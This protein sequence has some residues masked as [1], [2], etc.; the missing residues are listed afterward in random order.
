MVKY[1]QRL[2]VIAIL[3]A[4]VV[5]IFGALTRLHDAGLGCPDWPGCYGQLQIPTNAHVLAKAQAAYPGQIIEPLKA[6]WEMVH[7]YFAGTLG[8]LIFMMLGRSLVRRYKQEPAPL[9]LPLC[10]SILV[11]FQALLG[12]WTVTWKLHPVVVMSHLLG[13]IFVVTLLWLLL[14][15]ERLTQPI[16]VKSSFRWP[17]LIGLLMVI[18]QIAL[19]GWVSANYAS[20]A[21]PDFPT[22]HGSFWPGHLID[23]FHM[24]P[25][26]EN[27]EG[28]VLSHEARMM[29]HML[30]R[31]YGLLVFTYGTLFSVMW[32]IKHQTNI[33]RGIGAVLLI[34]LSVQVL[35]GVMNVVFNLPIT[36]AVLHNM[37]A[38]LILMTMATMNYLVWRKQ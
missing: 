9:L 4:C 32:M 21:C 13:G 20:L 19:G 35:L 1:Y 37:G 28:G 6:W 30:H 17:A 12:M 36:I 14:F 11:I 26:G 18:D 38:L 16:R 24:L 29:L 25:L 8:L 27:Y 31:Y 3:L 10:L 5:V 2:C 33:L 7:R 34:L 15:S 22:C 23:A